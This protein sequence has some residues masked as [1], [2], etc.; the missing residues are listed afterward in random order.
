MS[1]GGGGGRWHQGFWMWPLPPISPLSF[2]CEWP[3]AGIPLTRVEIDS[4]PLRDAA[5]RSRERFPSETSGWARH[6]VMRVRH[7][8]PA[9]ASADMTARRRN[10]LSDHARALEPPKAKGRA[11][12]PSRRM[13]ARFVRGGSVPAVVYGELRDRASRRWKASVIAAAATIIA[14]L[15]ASTASAPSALLPSPRPAAT[16]R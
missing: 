13:R 3:A 5:G 4:Q 2:V 1:G 16:P 10:A 11:H 12:N 15:V 8:E 7:R 14:T 9:Q 6:L